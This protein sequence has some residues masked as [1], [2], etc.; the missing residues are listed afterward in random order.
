MLSITF[1]ILSPDTLLFLQYSSCTTE[2]SHNGGKPWCSITRNFDLHQFWGFCNPNDNGG[3]IFPPGPVPGNGGW[4]YGPNPNIPAGPMPG[5]GG[6]PPS[7]GPGGNG[8]WPDNTGPLTPCEYYL[9]TV[10]YMLFVMSKLVT[11]QCSAVLNIV[12]PGSPC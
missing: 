8:G 3:G 1:N 11:D 2:G 10:Q 12:E 6:Y 4:P 9:N 7:Q 5:N